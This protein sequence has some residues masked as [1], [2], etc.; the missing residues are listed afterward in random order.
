[1]FTNLKSIIMLENDTGFKFIKVLNGI[2]ILQRKFLD[3]SLINTTSKTV[4]FA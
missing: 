1:M 3:G 4:L 2:L